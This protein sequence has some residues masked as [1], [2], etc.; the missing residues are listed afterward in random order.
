MSFQVLKIFIPTLLVG[1]FGVSGMTVAKND[2]KLPKA[3]VA[4]SE[5]ETKTLFSGKTIDWS[6]AQAFWFADGTSIGYYRQ[7][8]VESF[9]EGVWTVNGN[10]MCYENNWHNIDKTKPDV[11][12]KRCAKYYK[13]KKVIWTENTKDEDKYQGDIWPGV[14]KKLKNGDL[15]TKNVQ[16]LKLKSGY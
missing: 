3:A 12:D 2:G 10:E 14:T 15:V 7:G 8:K 11:K 1:I 4:L 13:V 9:A 16:T 5:E 6:V